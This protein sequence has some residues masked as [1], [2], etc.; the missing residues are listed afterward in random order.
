MQC[1]GIGS[2]GFRILSTPVQDFSIFQYYVMRKFEIDCCIVGI[3]MINHLYSST[4]H[5]LHKGYVSLSVLRQI[6][7]QNEA[8]D[9]GSYV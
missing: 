1:E 2:S 8:V 7:A 6:N 5:P 4:L 3:Y 9:D